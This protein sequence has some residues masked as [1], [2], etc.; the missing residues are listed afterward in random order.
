[1]GDEMSML[2]T[3]ISAIVAAIVIYRLYSVLGRRTGEERQRPNPFERQPDTASDRVVKLP[4]PGKP[5]SSDDEPVSVAD[6]L[7]RI[8]AVDRSFTEG[9][10]L[11]GAKIAFGMIIDAFAK[12]D[13]ETLKPLLAKSVFDGF[14]GAVRE[15]EA[16]GESLEIRIER[17][18]DIDIAEARLDG[19]TANVTLRFVTSQIK[20][21]RDRAGAIVDGDAVEPIDVTDLWTFSR[22]TSS[23]DPNWL[24]VATRSL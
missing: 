5:A 17:F 16:A 2:T 22:D 14:A 19:R 8:Q 12:G 23:R 7:A 4:I 18:E 11:G 15:R 13:L 20:V 1:M 21:T 9:S 3:I 10:F 6:G 24:L